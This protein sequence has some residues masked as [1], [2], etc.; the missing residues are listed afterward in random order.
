MAGEDYGTNSSYYNPTQGMA[1]GG[2]TEG[3]DLL[4]GAG[5]YRPSGFEWANLHKDLS[6]RQTEHWQAEA[7]KG[8][9]GAMWQAT[10]SENQ[11]RNWQGTASNPAQADNIRWA[12]GGFQPLQQRIENEGLSVSPEMSRYL[13]KN[14]EGAKP[15]PTGDLTGRPTLTQNTS[16][17][18]GD[19]GYMA[20]GQDA[21][22]QTSSFNHNS[23]YAGSG[24][25]WTDAAQGRG[26]GTPF[27]NSSVGAD[28][29]RGM[30]D[31]NVGPMPGQVPV[32]TQRL[33]EQHQNAILGMPSGGVMQ[34]QGSAF[35]AA[36]PQKE[37]DT[38]G[39]QA[40][41][42]QYDNRKSL[43][44]AP[45]AVPQPTMRN[46]E[47]QDPDGG[48]GMSPE[49]QGRDAG[50]QL[51]AAQNQLEWEPYMQDAHKKGLTMPTT[52]DVQMRMRRDPDFREQQ[53]AQDKQWKS[54]A[55]ARYE[56]EQLARQKADKLERKRLKGAP[57]ESQLDI[58]P[59][60]GRQFA[61]RQ[62]YTGGDM[63]VV[64]MQPVKGGDYK[65]HDP[66]RYGTP[67]DD[68]LYTNAQTKM[69]QK[70]S[71]PQI[72]SQSTPFDDELYDRSGGRKFTKGMPQRDAGYLERRTI[73]NPLEAGQQE[74]ELDKRAQV[75]AFAQKNPKIMQYLLS[76][77]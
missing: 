47:I 30:V 62:V 56:Q 64:G 15:L 41:T 49:E 36:A 29:G 17:F 61:E 77:A 25:P 3:A 26:S 65:A 10:A 28:P 33:L 34:Q 76:L 37:Y 53:Q 72:N 45:A 9:P 68:E 54:D 13:E 71:N 75:K 7:R 66:L 48:Y 70:G 52:K 69:Y 6:Q 23:G 74:G 58:N 73:G 59:Q 38:S 21:T 67:F 31:W 40:M 35:Q 2:N 27:N 42:P 24:S 12:R 18:G 11:Y 16:L 51:S 14:K 50:D 46:T 20:P 44:G 43:P 5:G 4:G 55:K 8:T 57:L 32:D 39:L 1:T 63:G 60:T 22:P 19:W